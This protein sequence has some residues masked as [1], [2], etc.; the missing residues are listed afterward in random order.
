VL[1]KV[2]QN[3]TQSAFCCDFSGGVSRNTPAPGYQQIH[4]YFGDS[5]NENPPLYTNSGVFEVDAFRRYQTWVGPGAQ[6]PASQFEATVGATDLL[7]KEAWVTFPGG[8]VSYSGSAVV[9]GVADIIFITNTTGQDVDTGGGSVDC[10]LNTNY[11]AHLPG[12]MKISVTVSKTGTG[13]GH[14]WGYMK[15]NFPTDTH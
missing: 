10:T 12:N 5:V 3:C 14:H 7:G 9:G 1:Y 2:R 11:Y 13:H 4:A 6:Q 15:A 8:S